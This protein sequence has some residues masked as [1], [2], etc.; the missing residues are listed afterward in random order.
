MD[1]VDRLEDGFLNIK[2]NTEYFKFELKI[3]QFEDERKE[4]IEKR[5]TSFGEIIYKEL[6]SMEDKDERFFLKEN[7][8]F[9][10]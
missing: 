3:K 2:R 7:G 10:N 1:I 5:K 4:T 6:K 9:L 8:K